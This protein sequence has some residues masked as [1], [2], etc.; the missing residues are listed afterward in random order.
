MSANNALGLAPARRV[1]GQ[2]E[3]QL[4]ACCTRVARSMR[5]NAIAEIGP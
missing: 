3:K 2:R 1:Q 5:A 4:A